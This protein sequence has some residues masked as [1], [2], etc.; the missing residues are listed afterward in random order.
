MFFLRATDYDP[1]SRT[2]TA[3]YRS[4]SGTNWC[5]YEYREVPAELYERVLAA[6]PHG[7]QVI[8][9]EVAP[10]HAV[11]RLGEHAWQPVERK[12]SD[13]VLTH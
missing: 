3:S 2:M 5:A 4:P 10:F 8:E 6:R 13:R 11:R 1:S 7:Q 12:A 9:D